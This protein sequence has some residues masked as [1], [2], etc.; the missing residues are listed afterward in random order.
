MNK[1]FIISYREN[2]ED[3]KYNLK[4]L[5]TWLSYV[6]DGN[7]EII[8]VE[9]DCY[10]KI[11]WLDEIKG[12]E[13]IKHIFVKNDGIFNVGW[14][15]NIGANQSTSDILIF[16]S[17]DLLVRHIAIKNSILHLD[18]HGVVK[19]YKSTYYLPK[20]E[21]IRF[22]ESQ[23]VL[24]TIPII[25]PVVEKLNTSG[26]FIMKKETFFNLKG[27]DEDCYG[28]GYECEIMDEKINKLGMKSFVMNDTSIHLH[29]QDHVNNTSDYYFFK[30]TNKVLYE[31]YLGMDK[32]NILFKIDKT[33][34]WGDVSYQ[35]TYDVSVRHLKRELYEKTAG[36][37][38]QFISSKFTDEY[39]EELTNS[40]SVMIFNSIVS[41]I[42]DKMTQE[43]KDINFNKKESILRRV[44][45]K[46]KI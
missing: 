5:L 30:N 44:M 20:E 32:S 2:S 4:V 45:K 14:G 38:L 9:Q 11:N 19:P 43:L 17:V 35:N 26:C 29:H 3:R 27:F 18:R 23:F 40:I 6:Q 34:K 12:N 25:V 21:T 37:I 42:K 39:I 46:F 28:Y 7:T 22:V 31:E 10:K 15:Y 1:S 8:I 13:F 24:P 41:G 33:L 16:N 36:D